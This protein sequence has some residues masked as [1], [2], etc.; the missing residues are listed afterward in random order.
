MERDKHNKR[1]YRKHFVKT[2]ELLKTGTDVDQ[3]DLE[4]RCI[5]IV[6]QT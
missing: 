3:T 5:T 6:R 1:Y 2:K 4:A